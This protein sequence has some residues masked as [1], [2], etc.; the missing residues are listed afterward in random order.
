MFAP[1]NL[2]KQHTGD[3]NSDKG[4]KE[5]RE[6]EMGLFEPKRVWMGRCGL[7]WFPDPFQTSA[8]KHRPGVSVGS[9]FKAVFIF[10]VGRIYRH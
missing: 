6:R 1:L 4:I 9:C 10:R 2:N 5:R 3:P 8:L 7:E